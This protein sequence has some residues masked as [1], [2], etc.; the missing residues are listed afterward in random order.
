VGSTGHGQSAGSVGTPPYQLSVAVIARIRLY[1]DGLADLLADA[2]GV[3]VVAAAASPAE[4]RERLRREPPDVVLLTAGSDEGPALVRRI[5]ALAPG[6]AVVVLG[7]ADDDLA[8]L[9]LAE[10]GVSGYVRIDASGEELL[11][12]VRAVSRGEAPCSP[13]ISGAL[14][15]RVAALARRETPP[16]PD[17]DLTAR[18]REIVGLIDD[19]LSNKEIATRLH[20]EVTTVKNHVHHVLEKLSVRRRGEAAAVVRRGAD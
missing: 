11:A 20:I 17:R 12:V 2:P 9:S 3:A 1:R 5:V 10:A 14:L 7:I 16:A 18:E 6:T 8:V 19:G 15:R 4:V 13:Q